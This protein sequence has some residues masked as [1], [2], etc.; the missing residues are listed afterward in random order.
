MKH[1][2]LCLGL[3]WGCGLPREV[4]I[5]AQPPDL[6]PAQPAAD[7]G[8]DTAQPDLGE[9]AGPD[10]V[11]HGIAPLRG[12]VDPGGALRV[13]LLVQNLG[14]LGAP[15]AQLSVVLEAQ[16]TQGLPPSAL[17][18]SVV[19]GLG[20]GDA[21]EGALSLELPTDLSPGRYRVV[22]QID[23]RALIDEQEEGN[24]S[25]LLGEVLVNDVLIEPRALEL[26]AAQGCE[27]KQQVLVRNLSRDS[28]RIMDAALSPNT[29]QSF[30]I[31]ARPSL[32]PGGE[33]G[34]FELRYAPL[35]PGG[36]FGELLIWHA[37]AGAPVRV[38]LAG[39]AESRPAMVDTFT[40]HTEQHVDILFVLDTTVSM[41]E[42][43]E[44]LA[45]GFA[46]FFTSAAVIG[47]D[48]HIAITSMDLSQGGEQGA[49]W[50]A[51][52]VLTPHVPYVAE[53]FHNHVTEMRSDRPLETGLEAAMRALS[54]PLIEGRNKGFLRPEAGLAIVFYS[55]E[56]DASP[57]AVSEYIGFLSEL[58]P[59][60]RIKVHALS[61]SAGGS[62]GICGQGLAPANRYY[63]VAR[64]F[65]G[66]T[67]EICAPDWSQV[68]SGLT[69]E[70]F[71][72]LTEVQLSE[73]PDVQSLV[74]ELDG[75]EV[76][77]ASGAQVHWTYDQEKNAVVFD[78]S[79][80]PLTNVLIEAKY[81]LRCSPR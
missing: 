38:Q 75:R 12:V 19:P 73:V 23:P 50:G 20:A 31:L 52:S 40:D 24:N 18:G 10:L 21:W 3:L 42:E 17:R 8:V 68:I 64:V 45:T 79:M 71:G 9:R 77:A 58:K 16:G 57:G 48:Y 44:A 81:Q 78:D 32:I 27:V 33:A 39:R 69:G 56:N 70:D 14:S 66:F 22:V 62:G 13:E 7:Q 5:G 80:N 37:R 53:F 34:T 25:A 2:L 55:D 4:S 72:L 49:F 76:P 35:A 15:E 59:P 65:G 47:I 41:T 63:D 43:N 60:E 1:Q 28:L 30:S 67:Q 36:E 51:P 6:G 61:A 74:V 11:V 29:P 26:S 54:L 46:P